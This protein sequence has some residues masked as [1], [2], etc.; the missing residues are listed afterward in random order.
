[1]SYYWIGRVIDCRPLPA[2]D[3]A[4]DYRAMEEQ[5]ISVTPLI[6]DRTNDLSYKELAG[7]NV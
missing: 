7:W 5:V 6:I 2:G 3:D 1:M 4:S